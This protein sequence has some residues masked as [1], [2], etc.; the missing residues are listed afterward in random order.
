M[1]ISSSS[2]QAEIVGEYLD[3]LSYDINGSTSQCARFIA[4]CRALLVMHPADW[5]HS[6]QRIMFRPDLWQ[7]QLSQA[8]QWYGSQASTGASSGVRHLSFEDFRS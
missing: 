3:T 7:Q 6:N 5:Q 8:E 2:T 1:A 4:A